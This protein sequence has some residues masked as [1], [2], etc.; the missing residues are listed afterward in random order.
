MI[1]TASTQDWLG[2]SDG[3][4]VQLVPF[5]RRG[6][7]GSDRQRFLKSAGPLALWGLNDLTFKPGEVPIHLIALGMTEGYGPNRNGDGFSMSVCRRYYKT[8][9]KH[10]RFYRNHV[11]KDPSR[12]YGIIKKAILNLPMRRIELIVALN[13]TEKAAQENGGLVADKELEKLSRQEDLP[14]SMS[15]K[16]SHDICSGCGN[17]A[18]TRAEYCEDVLEGGCCP[19]G[20]LK[21]HITK[22]SEDGHVLFADNPDP[23]WFDISHV[24]RPADRTAYVTGTLTNTTC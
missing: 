19:Y 1:K 12:S 17:R 21:Y 8:F 22:V 18:K 14:V 7:R 11:N 23:I 3:P 6:L 16:V 4:A 5:S 15:C 24:F 2:L 9:E 10:A 20:G 13:G